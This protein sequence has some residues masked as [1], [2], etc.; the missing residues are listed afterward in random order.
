[1]K[2]KRN[3]NVRISADEHFDILRRFIEAMLAGIFGSMLAGGAEES[4]AVNQAEYIS[5][6]LREPLNNPFKAK[7]TEPVKYRLGE[8]H[9][10]AF[11]RLL[12][13]NS[14]NLMRIVT[15]SPL[16]FTV[17]EAYYEWKWLVIHLDPGGPRLTRTDDRN[18]I[19]RLHQIKAAWDRSVNVSITVEIDGCI[20]RTVILDERFDGE[21]NVV[22]AKRGLEQVSG[23]IDERYF[24]SQ[25]VA[26]K[27]TGA[28][29]K[30][31]SSS[32]VHVENETL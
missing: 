26:S 1:L 6:G 30:R 14:A 12:R 32:S 29:R 27:A 8:E 20:A 9:W 22:L 13:D 10:T 2:I 17:E 4:F 28:R 31:R 15:T 25:S 7:K 16:N 21:S 24:R 11:S 19:A 18:N 3:T 23:S 5:L